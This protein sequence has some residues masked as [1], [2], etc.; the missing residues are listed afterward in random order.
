MALPQI[1]KELAEKI[2]VMLAESPLDEEVK[3]VILDNLDKMP[4]PLVYRL[5]D[6]LEMEKESL[7][8]VVSE[9]ERFAREQNE[10]WDDIA[11]QQTQKTDEIIDAW[12]KK[13]ADEEKINSIKSSVE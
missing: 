4:M 2:G 5:V 9:I 13:I 1:E 6:C 3:K 10:G 8:I 11:K 12:A 7:A